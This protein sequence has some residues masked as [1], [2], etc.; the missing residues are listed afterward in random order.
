MKLCCTLHETVL[1]STLHTWPALLNKTVLV[2]IH[3]PR[4]TIEEIVSDSRNCML[5]RVEAAARTIVA[6]V[7]CDEIDGA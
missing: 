3:D 4:I 2:T 5:L 6:E 1:Y 7:D